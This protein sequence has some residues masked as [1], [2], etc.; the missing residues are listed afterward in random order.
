MEGAGCWFRLPLSISKHAKGYGSQSR[1]TARPVSSKRVT[2]LLSE[3]KRMQN[4]GQLRQNISEQARKIGPGTG[5]R[6]RPLPRRM[7]GAGKREVASIG[8]PQD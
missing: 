4:K 7:P 5:C 1:E 8:K 2:C 6:E 3:L